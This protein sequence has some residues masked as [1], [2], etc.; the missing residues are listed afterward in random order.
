MLHNL[1]AYKR[2]RL[3]ICCDNVYN[4]GSNLKSLKKLLVLVFNQLIV[5]LLLH[6]S[7]ILFLWRQKCRHRGFDLASINSVFLP[8]TT[9]STKVEI[10]PRPDGKLAPGDKKYLHNTLL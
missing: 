8:I 4:S 10:L 7:L 6:L 9:K 2:A 5:F 3:F 1:C